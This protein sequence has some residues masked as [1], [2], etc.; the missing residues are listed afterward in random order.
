M[1]GR[2]ATKQ[3]HLI[4]MSEPLIEVMRKVEAMTGHKEFIFDSPRDI[5]K[6]LSFLELFLFGYLKCRQSLILIFQ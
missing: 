5:V 2:D 3:E 4:P 6:S 1:K